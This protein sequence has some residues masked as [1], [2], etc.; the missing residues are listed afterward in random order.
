MRLPRVSFIIPTMNSR[1][2]L[3]RNLSS[4]REQDYP[5][6]EVIVVDGGSTDGTIEIAEKYADRVL[7]EPGTLGYARQKWAELATGEILGIFDSDIYLPHKTWLTNA[8]RSLISRKRAAI[9]WPINI[10]PVRAS[11]TARA[12]FALWEYRLRTSKT[13]VPGGNI[14]VK[15]KAYD[16]VGGFNPKLH[17]GEDYD[18]TLKILRRGYTYIIY[19]DPVIHDTMYSLRQYTRKQ[20]WGARSLSEAEREIVS[21]TVSWDPGASSILTEGAKH[22][23]QFIASIPLGIQRYKDPWLVFYSPLMMAIRAVVYG[24]YYL[25]IT[26]NRR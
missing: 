11:H 3:E 17:F 1:R 10:P 6:V 14:L 24:F 25:K 23:W 19:P 5:E 13:P 16:E 22:L 8:V 7:V 9:L 4:I 15:R 2:T 12:Y 21:A 20:F 18:L 26:R